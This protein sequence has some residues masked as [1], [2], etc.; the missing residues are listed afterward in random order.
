MELVLENA[1]LGAVHPDGKTIAFARDGK[2]WI[3]SLKGGQPRVFWPAPLPATALI[4]WQFSPDGSLLAVENSGDFWVLPYPSGAP[5]RLYTLG[6][7]GM[8]WGGSWFPDSRR[9]VVAEEHY[10]ESTSA[11]IQIDVRGGHRRTIYPS[12]FVEYPSVAPDGERIA[13]DIGGDSAEVISVS[14]LDGRLDATAGEADAF[15]PDWA[16]SGTHFLFNT[17]SNRSQ[18]QA[19]EDRDAANAGFSRRLI[20]G[21]VSQPRWSPDGTRFVFAE[22]SSPIVKVKVA[23]A[24]SGHA[25]ALDEFPGHHPGMSWSP[26]GQWISYIRG[27]EG[28][29]DL[30]K[31]RAVPGST[32]VVLAKSDA[33][34]PDVTQWSP[35]GDWILY[36]AAGGLDLITPD[37]KTTRKLT[38]RRF[39]AYNF[40]RDGSQVYGIFENTSG[41]GAQWQLYSVNVRTGA[42]KL[43]AP[44]DLPRSTTF[45]IGLSIHPDGKRFLTSI[46][47]WRFDVWMME[48]FEQPQSKNW[49]TRMLNR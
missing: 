9:I 12:P 41:E 17:S 2:L 23:S 46:V 43:V 30:A 5:R 47:K 42:E 7:Q 25:V 31:V 15:W 29:Q 11:L 34:G 4:D 33:R 18:V 26:D 32:P 38:G 37:G 44:V 19:I 16:P 6:N 28:E 27:R 21:S 24:S 20:E 10:R 36:P 45:L 40:S 8:L 13:Y 3:G 14:L 39:Q 1:H 49:L 35:V 22:I 48:G